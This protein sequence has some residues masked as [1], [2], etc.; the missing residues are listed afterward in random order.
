MTLKP[1][2]IPSGEDG[3]LFAWPASE[4]KEMGNS[5][6]CFWLIAW[7]GAREELSLV[8][9]QG[10]KQESS[11][12]PRGWNPVDQNLCPSTPVVE[13]CIKPAHGP[14]PGCMVTPLHMDFIVRLPG[15]L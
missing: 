12:P 10:S 5:G 15:L 1:M 11:Q 6:A 7:W 3:E 13:S 8:G 14:A 9:Q 2:S 4:H